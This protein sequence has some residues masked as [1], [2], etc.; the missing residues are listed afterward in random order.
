MSATFRFFS[1]SIKDAQELS[2]FDAYSIDLITE[3]E[4]LS[5]CNGMDVSETF[6]DLSIYLLE[7]DALN[8]AFI[9][10]GSFNLFEE[11]FFT[12]HFSLLFSTVL[13]MLVWILPSSSVSVFYSGTFL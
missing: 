12:D 11:P 5:D 9:P 2:L 8:F 3:T 1:D 7:R 10:I 13:P 6:S 4:E